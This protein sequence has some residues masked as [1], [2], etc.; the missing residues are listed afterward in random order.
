METL[1]VFYIFGFGNGYLSEQA[2]ACEIKTSTER[3]LLSTNEDLDEELIKAETAQI[4]RRAVSRLRPTERRVVIGYLAGLNPDEI[5][6]R[7]EISTE[8]VKI[9]WTQARLK[10]RRELEPLI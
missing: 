2:S 8:R 5:A 4:V 9:V 10:L 7:C 6:R 1:S 3:G